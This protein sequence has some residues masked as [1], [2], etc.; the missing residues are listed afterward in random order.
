MSV[1]MATSRSSWV[2]M[3]MANFWGNHWSE[4]TIQS[5]CVSLDQT[6]KPFFVSLAKMGLE[7][8]CS[9]VRIIFGS[10]V[11]EGSGEYSTLSEDF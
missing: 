9:V 4:L 6:V 11:F 5:W 1:A 3:G 8:G 7:V 10:P 2:A